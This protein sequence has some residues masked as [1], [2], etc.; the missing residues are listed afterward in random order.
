MEKTE[1]GDYYDY[2]PGQGLVFGETPE[3]VAEKRKQ[4]MEGL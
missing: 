4:Y 3:Q 2:V 1:E